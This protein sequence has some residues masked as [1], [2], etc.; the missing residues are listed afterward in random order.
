MY[1]YPW[2]L[3]QKCF[4]IIFSSF[5]ETIVGKTSFVQSIRPRSW[6]SENIR[7]RAGSATSTRRPSWT[8]STSCSDSTNLRQAS[9]ED[10][11]FRWERWP[12]GS[13]FSTETWQEKS[14]NFGNCNNLFPAGLN[15]IHLKFT[16][17][18]TKTWIWF[19]MKLFW[20]SLF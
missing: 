5:T 18:L 20:K 17:L 13:W 6:S 12:F 3:I 9:F 7:R 15:Q 16:K 1:E 4:I 2:N 14:E 8:W 11:S 10:I 19:N